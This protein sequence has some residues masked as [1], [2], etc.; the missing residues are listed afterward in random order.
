MKRKFTMSVLLGLAV[1]FLTVACKSSPPSPEPE[2]A[3]LVP[4]PG[5]TDPNSA[6]PDQ[7]LLR[8][9]DEAIKRTD[10][11]RK[12]VIDFNGPAYFPPEWQS[13][14]ALRSQAEQQKRTSTVLETRDSIAL[15][16]KAADAYEALVGKTVAKYRDDIIDEGLTARYAAVRAE[17]L[18]PDFI[19]KADNTALGADEKYK[20]KDYYGARDDARNAITMYGLL[21]AGLDAYKVREEIANRDF[22]IYD[23]VNIEF[24]DGRLES[25]A[26]DYTAGNF[27]ASRDKIEEAALRYNLALKTAWESFAADKGADASN[28]RQ[29]ALDLKANVAV[30]QEFN[31]AQAVFTNA[32]TAFSSQK[33]EDAAKL[34]AESSYM[35]DAVIKVAMKKRLA[36]EEALEKANQKIAESDETAKNAERILE[37]GTP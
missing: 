19:T 34:F 11:A 1:L 25:A 9:L 20:A 8:T 3:V 16:N 5:V 7:A 21:K 13:A 18:I 28:V 26:S 35:F 10:N 24:A 31:S 32:N 17:E 36:A 6:P 23:P 12:L 29:Q 27:D 37:G 14:E 30:R 2:K 4:S 22:E 15:Y 33:H